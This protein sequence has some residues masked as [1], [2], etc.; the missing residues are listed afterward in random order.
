MCSCKSRRPA[1][2]EKS[3]HCKFYESF[4]HCYS[5]EHLSLAASDTLRVIRLVLSPLKIFHSLLRA[6]DEQYL[7]IVHT[8]L[9]F[10]FQTNNPKKN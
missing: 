4:Q 10:S 1:L 8:D 3:L 5:K 9:C 6:V 7:N 2:L